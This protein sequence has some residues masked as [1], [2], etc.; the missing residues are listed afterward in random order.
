[1]GI[2]DEDVVRVRE[3]TD[4]VAIVSEYTQLKR[5]GLRYQ[6]L[7]PF[8]AE[9][10]GSFSVNAEDGLY[11]CF[12]CGVGGDIITF[13]QE[14]EQLDFVAAVEMLAN[15]A[16][17]TLRY[18]TSGQGEV[19]RRK[20]ILQET[21]GKA[22]EWYHQRLLTSADAGPARSYLRQRGYDGDVVRRY[23]I[24]WA[25]EGWDLLAKA[26]RVSDE[27]LTDSGL[28]FVNRFGRQQD[29]F[30]GRI[31]FP[32]FDA[33]GEAVG[34]GGRI[35]PGH[36]GPKYKNSSES[37][38]YAKSRVLYGLHWAKTAIVEADE[39]I[40]CEG[41]TDVIGFDLAGAG[42]AVATCGTA[43]TEEHVKLLRRFARRVV[44]AFDADAAGQNAAARFY[45]WEKA[46]DL[47]VAVVD[48]GAGVDPADLAQSDP[49][50]LVQ[51]VTEAR[52]FLEFRVD[53]AIDGVDRSTA[54]GRAKAAERAMAMVAEHP[55][56]LVRD[57]YVMM[58]A[59]RCQFEPDLIRSMLAEGAQPRQ[60]QRPSERP[61]AA[62]NRNTAEL[63]AL[64]LAVHKGQEVMDLLVPD[65]F[66]EPRCATV[67][68]LFCKFSSL[69]DVIEHGGPEVAE[70][71]QRL[72][73]EESTADAL[74]VAA[75]LWRGYLGRQMDE[76]RAKAREATGEA[77]ALLAKDFE[78]FR[79][80]LE[81]LQDPAQKASTVESL[82]GWVLED[83]E[84][85]S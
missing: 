65:L 66:V 73:V 85:D 17:V 10:T 19:R 32:I 58:V 22:V 8:H 34:F 6:G 9:K 35:M 4:M 28:G 50:R 46:H 78:W 39:V 16:N 23:R 64:R 43:L 57:Q 62:S 3:V 82:L 15:K 52:P 53:R 37:T 61:Q 69:H 14:K 49:A 38:V 1:M 24:G 83:L 36:D 31:Q 41:Y 70:F 72:A 7:C 79:L 45:E 77:S 68:D 51:V 44:L 2:V 11:Y 20:A 74:D 29:A 40:V 42:R 12:G 13:V 54:E 81:Q 55:D 76:Y 48:M 18:T 47:D 25:P 5:V 56:R 71:V 21:I 26:L 59:S 60:A 30:R 80:Q 63:E 33:Q 75:L 67:Y 27:D 84:E